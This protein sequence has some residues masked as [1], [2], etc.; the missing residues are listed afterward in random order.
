MDAIAKGIETMLSDMSG[1]ETQVQAKVLRTLS[2]GD[3]DIVMKLIDR[4]SPEVRTIINEFEKQDGRLPTADEIIWI[5]GEHHKVDPRYV[6][7]LLENTIDIAAIQAVKIAIQEH[8][9]TVAQ[10]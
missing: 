9:P 1:E 6:D 8:K 3:N 5:I 7:R 2:G 10:L 4:I